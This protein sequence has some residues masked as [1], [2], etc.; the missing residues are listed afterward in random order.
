MRT[1]KALLHRLMLSL[2]LFPLGLGG[3]SLHWN[4]VAPVPKD[5]AHVCHSVP[6]EGKKHVYVFL[7]QGEDVLDC[8]NL[9]GLKKYLHTIG[10]SKVWFGQWYHASHF[11]KVIREKFYHDGMA[12]FVVIGQGTG[13][14][15]ARD[16]AANV[17]S[18][19]IYFDLM[20]Y[21]GGT[22]L[23]HGSGDRPKNAVRVVNIV[24]GKAVLKGA[25]IDGAENIIHRKAH[26][27]Q[28][29]T[30]SETTKLLCMELTRIAGS[31]PVKVPLPVLPAPQ[32]IRHPAPEPV[33]DKRDA[34]DFLKPVPAG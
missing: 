6:Q 12:R 22:S 31:I 32:G 28:L 29:A 27:L 33:D 24:G 1:A 15:H 8:A 14:K 18:E 10:F 17:A 19:G 3:C 26:H 4:N 2:L 34:W 5:L 7:I 23:I 20:V 9:K 21:L 16:I 11:E 30:H 25:I 13:A